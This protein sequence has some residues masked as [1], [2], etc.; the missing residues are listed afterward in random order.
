MKTSQFRFQLSI[1][2]TLFLLGCAPAL[3]I[4]PSGYVPSRNNLLRDPYGAY[5]SFW[6]EEKSFEGELLGMRNDSVFV[7]GRTLARVYSGDIKDGQLIIYSPNKLSG[8]L[9]MMLPNA[10]LLVHVG[11]YGSAP[12]AL[13]LSL[14]VI[15]FIGTLPAMALEKE[16]T[17]YRKWGDG[18]T[19]V[20][21]Y[22]RF[23]GGIPND[24]QVT[25]L[26]RRP[27]VKGR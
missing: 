11:S 16:I 2:L 7:L 22:S 26:T 24:M 21:R 23:P 20:M 9:V 6:T 8:G 13:A 10:A 19:A 27:E 5:F 14:S 25:Q 3:P 18:W 12:A 17:N 4:A 15:D 1:L